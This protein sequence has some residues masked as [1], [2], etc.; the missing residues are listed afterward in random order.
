MRF[1]HH[2]KVDGEKALDRECC[3]AFVPKAQHTTLK[4][5]LVLVT[6]TPREVSQ[7]KPEFPGGEGRQKGRPQ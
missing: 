7:H 2:S 5:R 1:V 6:F 4:L 3:F